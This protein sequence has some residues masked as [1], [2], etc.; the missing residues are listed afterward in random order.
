MY[1]CTDWARNPSQSRSDFVW[2][3]AAERHVESGSK[4]QSR[5]F[6]SGLGV[7]SY[8]VNRQD[9]GQVGAKEWLLLRNLEPHGDV[10]HGEQ[11]DD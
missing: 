1:P 2:A 3:A 9:L 6:G 5:Q 10:L 11:A 4:I 7:K 8:Q